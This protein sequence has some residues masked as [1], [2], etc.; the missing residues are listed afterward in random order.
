MKTCLH[1]IPFLLLIVFYQSAIAREVN[2]HS[3]QAGL[4]FLTN[5]GQLTDQYYQ[6][7]PDTDFK[8][9]ATGMDIFI[10][11]GAIHNQFMNRDLG[12]FKDGLAGLNPDFLDLGDD[13]AKENTKEPENP[14]ISPNPGS[15]NRGCDIYRL[16]VQLVG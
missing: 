3:T 4:Y 5:A 6:P 8:L 12:G 9:N 13:Q 1:A 15:N 16:D 2:P 10:G 14:L 11:D 7:R